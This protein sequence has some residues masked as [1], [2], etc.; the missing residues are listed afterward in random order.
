MRTDPPNSSMEETPDFASA[1]EQPSVGIIR[2]FFYFLASNKK[3]WMIPLVLVM[4]LVGGLILLAS[5]PAIAPFIYSL[6]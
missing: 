3:W 5:T 1:A 4:V 6:F 2:E